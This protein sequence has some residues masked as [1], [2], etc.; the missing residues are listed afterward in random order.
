[1]QLNI[2]KESLNGSPNTV[3]RSS[4]LYLDHPTR[5]RFYGGL[6]M[7]QLLI[8]RVSSKIALVH[9]ESYDRVLFER[10]HTCPLRGSTLPSQP[11]L[12]RP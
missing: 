11:L 4:R 2:I 12:E 1:M 5:Q 3:S 7:R 6:P 9:V 8:F 10:I